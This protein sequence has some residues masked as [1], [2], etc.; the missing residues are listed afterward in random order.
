[1]K[2]QIARIED[3]IAVS[4][5]FRDIKSR[6]EISHILAELEILKQE[7]LKKWYNFPTK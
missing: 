1:M 7:L 3:T 6:G 4:K 2:I 5:D